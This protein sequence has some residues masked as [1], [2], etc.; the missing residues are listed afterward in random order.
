MGQKIAGPRC[1]V[2]VHLVIDDAGRHDDGY[3]DLA[4][5]ANEFL[6]TG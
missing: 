6:C 3:A 1:P 5:V 4:Q 2:A